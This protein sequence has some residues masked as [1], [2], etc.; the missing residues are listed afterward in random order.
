MRKGYHH[1]EAEKCK[2]KD[3]IGLNPRKIAY[4]ETNDNFNFDT[5]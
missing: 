5:Q 1:E 3:D 4:G 2:N